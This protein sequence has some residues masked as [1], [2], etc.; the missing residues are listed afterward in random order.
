MEYEGSH[1]EVSLNVMNFSILQQFSFEN[2]FQSIL[3]IISFCSIHFSTRYKDKSTEEKKVFKNVLCFEDIYAL[4][5]ACNK[6]IAANP[7]RG[8]PC[9]HPEK[10]DADAA[11]PICT[12]IQ[13]I[14]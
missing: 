1:F 4:R 9:S 8:G 14:E 12:T 7:T 5:D 6:M 3:A 10:K 2:Q 11:Q 13:A